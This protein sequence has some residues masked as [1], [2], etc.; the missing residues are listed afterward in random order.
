[1]ISLVEISIE[2]DGWNGLN[3]AALFERAASATFE[4]LGLTATGYLISVLACDDN[5]IQRLNKEFRGK[6]KA[7]NVLSWP[8]EDCDPDDL[9]QPGTEDD[10][11]ELGDI[12]IAFQ[13]MEREAS[14]AEMPLEDHIMHLAVHSI[15]HLFGYDHESD[16]DAAL[17]EATETQILAT[18]GVPDPY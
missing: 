8:S 5:E 12:A 2:S 17:M 6:A 7:T 16:S 9:P 3:L 14:E 4:H 18:L 15:L 11:V 10:P 13:T 1:M